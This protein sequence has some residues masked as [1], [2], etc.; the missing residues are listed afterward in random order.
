MALLVSLKNRIRRN[1]VPEDIHREEI[2]ILI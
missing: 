2:T 1:P